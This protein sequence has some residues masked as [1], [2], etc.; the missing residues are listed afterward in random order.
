MT[1]DK[2]KTYRDSIAIF[3]KLW[4][5]ICSECR[6]AL[7]GHDVPLFSGFWGCS[8]TADRDECEDSGL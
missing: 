4:P 6:A 7:P 3:K 5:H 8:A 2:M 1:T